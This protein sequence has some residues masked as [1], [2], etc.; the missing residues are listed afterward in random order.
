MGRNG[1]GK[2]TLLRM[3]AGLIE[4]TRGKVVRAGRVALLLQ[5]PGDYFLH[6]RIG[7]D[8]PNAGA[9]ADRHP[10]DVSGGERQRLALEIVL[11]VRDAAGRGLPRRADARD[12]PWPRRP[13]RRAA[14]R[15]SPPTAPPCWSPPTTPS[16]PPRGPTAR[17]CW[18]TA[19]RWPTRRPP[20]CSAAAGTSRRRPRACSAAARC[21][22]RT[23][24][25][26]CARANEEVDAVSWV[27]ASTLIL[28]AALVAGFAW[29][30][31]THPSTRVIALVATLAALAAIG[32]IAFAALPNVKPTTDIVFIS[33]F[34]LGGAPG[35]AVGVGRRARLE[36]LLR[37]GTVDAVADGRLGRRRRRSA[38]CSATSPTAGSAARISRSRAPARAGDVRRVDEHPPVGHLLRRAHAGRARRLLRD[39]TVVRRRARG[40][41]RGLLPRVRARAGAGARPLPHALRRALARR[42]GRG[43]RADRGRVRGGCARPGTGVGRRG[44]RRGG[45]GVGEVPDRAPRTTTAAGAARRGSRRRSCTRAGPRSGSPPPGATRAT[46]GSRARSRTSAPHANELNDL[47]ELN[48]TL[49]ILRASGRGTHIGGRDLEAEV[50]SQQRRNGSFGGRVNTTAFAVL[51]LRAAGRAKRDRAIRRAIAWI[52]REANDDGGFNF[53]GR[54]GPV[55]DRRHGRGPAGARRGR[56]AGAARS[57][58]GP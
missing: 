3:L 32:R 40:R 34:V 7:D 43:D 49:L 10:R 41:Q 35:F 48:R 22:P 36:H 31:R 37:A 28:G 27:V 20:R 39:V 17:S 55:R 13:A 29:Y 57:P 8:L 46:S 56:A 4:P 30:E 5:N 58:S 1:A 23:A 38:R 25:R 24:R 19:C 2:S 42:A 6:D 54:G 12:G 53:A 51:G 44:R 50:A 15:R 14:A 33:G 26:C 47:G 21:C 9:L 52:M 11:D 16:S 18:A 45:A